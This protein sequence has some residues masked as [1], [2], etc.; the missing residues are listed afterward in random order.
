[1]S[2]LNDFEIFSSENINY[3]NCKLLWIGI[4]IETD[5]WDHGITSDALGLFKIQP[6]LTEILTDSANFFLS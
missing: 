4:T 2:D 5:S 3:T 6:S 1:M